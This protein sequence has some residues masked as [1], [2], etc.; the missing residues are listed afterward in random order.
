MAALVPVSSRPGLASRTRW[1]IRSLWREPFCWSEPETIGLQAED[2]TLPSPPGIRLSPFSGITP[3]RS[4]LSLSP[5]PYS[6]RKTLYPSYFLNVRVSCGGM[7]LL[8]QGALSTLAPAWEKPGWA[9]GR[10]NDR[11]GRSR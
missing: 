6:F 2:S 11:V 4:T 3:S 9:E 5:V 8:G 7:L 10:V 1:S